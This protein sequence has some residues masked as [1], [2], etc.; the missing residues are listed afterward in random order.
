LVRIFAYL[1]PKR[2]SRLCESFAFV[3]GAE[4]GRL[5][6]E[7]SRKPTRRDGGVG[8]VPANGHR[9]G[10][11][12]MVRP[13]PGRDG[14]T[15]YGIQREQRLKSQ[16]CPRS[17]TNRKRLIGR[18]LADKATTSGHTMLPIRWL[19][20]SPGDIGALPWNWQISLG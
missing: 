14:V 15:S 3:P 17:I 6:A 19:P 5:M 16:A 7:M 12:M 4:I 8:W 10:S 11:M 20:I 1:V 9:L 18:K 2:G 13:A